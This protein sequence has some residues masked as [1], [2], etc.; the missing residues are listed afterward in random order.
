[1][2]QEYPE[3]TKTLKV[4]S[5]PSVKIAEVQEVM[6][7]VEKFVVKLYGLNDEEIS[8]VDQARAFLF[9]K[10]H[11]F[12][13]MPPSSNV[14]TFHVLRASYEVKYCCGSYLYTIGNRKTA[15]LSFDLA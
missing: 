7:T 8:T 14:L 3:F 10:G 12:E 11:T 13:N 1:M 15:Y 4:L 5:K 2:W 6:H 9:D